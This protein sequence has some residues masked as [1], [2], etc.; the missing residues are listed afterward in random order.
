MN[1]TRN[2]VK[3]VASFVVGQSVSAVVTS[4]VKNLVPADSNTLKVKVFVGSQVLGMMVADHAKTYTNT[5]IDETADMI[6]K[7][8]KKTHK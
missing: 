8:S 5:M 2:H 7:L 6:A 1:I 3:V 4:S